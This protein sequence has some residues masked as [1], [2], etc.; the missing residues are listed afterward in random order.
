VLIAEV[1]L[2]QAVL[3]CYALKFRKH[4]VTDRD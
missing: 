3:R 1:L 2:N 4:R